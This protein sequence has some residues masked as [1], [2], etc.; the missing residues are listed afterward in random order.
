M[1]CTIGFFVIVEEVG[2]LIWRWFTRWMCMY[3]SVFVDTQESDC[4][5]GQARCLQGQIRLRFCYGDAHSGMKPKLPKI[6]SWKTIWCTRSGRIG[7]PPTR[8]Y[9]HKALA[10]LSY[11]RSNMRSRMSMVLI[12]FEKEDF[13]VLENRP[14]QLVWP[15]DQ[16]IRSEVWYHSDSTTGQ[17]ASVVMV[18]ISTNAL[19]HAVACDLARLY[20]SLRPHLAWG[21]KT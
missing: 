17:R 12:W 15:F 14:W 5:A 6:R 18:T 19:W 2:N 9:A 16:R 10:P 13:L 21:S 3:R 1:C 4:A 7:P 8:N 11:K 20:S